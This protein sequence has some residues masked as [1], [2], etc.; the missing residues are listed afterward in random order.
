MICDSSILEFDR[1]TGD[2]TNEQFKAVM[3]ATSEKVGILIGSAGTGKSW[4]VARLLKAFHSDAKVIACAPTGKAATRMNELLSEAGINISC[5]TIHATLKPKPFEGPNGVSFEFSMNEFDKIDADA[6]IVDES[7]MIDNSLMASLIKAMR[8]ETS[9]LFVGD[10]NQLPPVGRGRPFFDMIESGVVP[11]GRLETVHRYSGRTGEVCN[12]I[13]NNKPWKP[14]QKLDL[15]CESPENLR[16][17]ECET[18]AHTAKAVCDTVSKIKEWGYDII[19][20]T[21]V[22]VALNKDRLISREQLNKKLRSIYNTNKNSD[23]TK[24]LT[25]GDKIILKNNATVDL[26]NEKENGE[27]PEKPYGEAYTCNGDIGIVVDQIDDHKKIVIKLWNPERRIILSG[28][29]VFRADLAY[30]ITCHKFQGSGCPFVIVATTG[31][32]AATNMVCSREWTYTALSRSQL[33]TIVC[34]QKKHLDQYCRERVIVKR[35]TFLKERLIHAST[36]EK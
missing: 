32:F 18:D 8:D 3:T 10:P 34:G 16:V 2:L 33:A 4:T 19:E 1:S 9:I 27:Y 14:S 31:D 36:G 29:D 26:W 7:S 12:A 35:K 22:I 25:V 5:R 15:E 23:H 24:R 30:A 13:I 6:I 28:D 11:V 17:I 21:Q 20:D